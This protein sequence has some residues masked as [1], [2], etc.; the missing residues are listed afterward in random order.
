MTDQRRRSTL[1][2][3]GDTPSVVNAP[4]KNPYEIRLD[5]L[6]LAQEMAT[7]KFKA[8]E[9]TF[10]LV[11]SGYNSYGNSV[12]SNISFDQLSESRASAILAQAP[13]APSAAEIINEANMLYEF[14]S[15]NTRTSGN[16]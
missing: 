13:K 6:K 11:A 8:D 1:T 3:A 14:V 9:A 4:S 15:N 10:G 5:V 7:L 12:Q 2:A 16:K